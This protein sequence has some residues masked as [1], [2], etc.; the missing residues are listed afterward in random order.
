MDFYSLRRAGV[1]AI[2][3]LTL[4]ACASTRTVRQSD[5][6]ANAG[7]AYGDAAQDVII[8]TRDRYLDWQS[9]AMLAGLSGT[10]GVGKPTELVGE[11]EPSQDCKDEIIQF[12]ETAESSQANIQQFSDLSDHADALGRYFQA[13]KSL[14]SY[15]ANGEVSTA[16]QGLLTNLNTLSDKLETGAKITDAQKTAWSKLAGLVG[17]S[18]KAAHLRRR[19]REDAAAIG[20]AIDVQSGVLDANAALLE[21]MDAAVRRE[22][23]I[24]KV[25]NP[26][27]T[28]TALSNPAAWRADRR[29]ALLPPPD[30]QQLRTL[31]SASASLKT[32]WEDILSGRGSPEAAQQVFDDIAHA[33]KLI[34]DVREAN[35]KKD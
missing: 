14:A 12:G 34:R 33:L 27:L 23:F 11:Q 16:T 10:A 18:I 17:D 20:R 5:Q 24:K 28:G 35:E 8:L 9:D 19:L 21:A 6:L 26:Y 3:A 31:R 30:I 15:D 13:L 32:V 7:I 2:L 29:L 4:C 22:H 25:R 1:L